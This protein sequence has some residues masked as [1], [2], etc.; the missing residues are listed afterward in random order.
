MP[1]TCHARDQEN[2]CAVWLEKLKKKGRLNEL[3]K[4]GIIIFM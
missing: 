2:V 3:E 4:D 1:A